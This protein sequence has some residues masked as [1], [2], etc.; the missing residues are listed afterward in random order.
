MSPCYPHDTLGDP[1]KANNPR[2]Y[3][4]VYY[5]LA[6]VYRRSCHDTT[7]DN[8]TQTTSIVHATTNSEAYPEIITVMILTTITA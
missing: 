6:M 1:Q 4:G 7:Q 2:F 8:P 3:P 5:S